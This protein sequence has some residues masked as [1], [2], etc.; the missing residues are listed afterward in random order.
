M[1]I[2]MIE[3]GRLITSSDRFHVHKSLGV[4]CLCSFLFS[5]Q[6]MFI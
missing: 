1:V 3:M 4:V 2:Y 6:N 5:Y